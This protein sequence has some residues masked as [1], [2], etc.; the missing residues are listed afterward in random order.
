VLPW[1]VIAPTEISLLV[2]VN[3]GPV[4]HPWGGGGGYIYMHRLSQSQRL[5]LY[6]G[7]QKLSTLLASVSVWHLNIAT[8]TVTATAGY[9]QPIIIT[10]VQARD[11]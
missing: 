10:K 2:S 8:V 3:Q 4:T 5:W 11:L 6:I 1:L 7:R 9:Q